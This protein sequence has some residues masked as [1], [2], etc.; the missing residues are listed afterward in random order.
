MEHPGPPTIS[1]AN[2]N[3]GRRR[4]SENPADAVSQVVGRCND[5]RGEPSRS[6]T[7]TQAD[8]AEQAIGGGDDTVDT[9][10]TQCTTSVDRP[11]TIRTVAWEVRASLYSL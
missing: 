5:E 2:E 9:M 8:A 7:P 11:G 10:E 4:H 3:G 6:G 1:A